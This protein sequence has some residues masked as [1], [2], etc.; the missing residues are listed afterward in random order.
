RT[1]RPRDALAVLDL[2]L[3]QGCASPDVAM[4]A[5]L[6]AMDVGQHDAQLTYLQYFEQIEPNQPWT[7]YYTALALLDL[8]RPDEAL[9]AMAEE[10]KRSPDRTFGLLVLRAC[11]AA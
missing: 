1:E 9:Q 6:L 8:K 11:A 4:E 5:A 3:R 2:C 7:M 10:E